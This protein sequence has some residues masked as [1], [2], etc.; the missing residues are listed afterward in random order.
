MRLQVSEINIP[1]NLTTFS[2]IS[3]IFK[4]SKFLF[5]FFFFFSTWNCQEFFLEYWKFLKERIFFNK[6]QNFYNSSGK[7]SWLKFNNCKILPDLRISEFHLQSQTLEIKKEQPRP[8]KISVPI[9][10]R[11][12]ILQRNRVTL[13]SVNSSH[14]GIKL[15]G[16]MDIRFPAGPP[17]TTRNFAAV[18]FYGL[19]LRSI[20]AREWCNELSRFDSS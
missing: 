2:S 13:D 14:S 20:N 17:F 7:K 4:V 10:I 11:K 12:R 5:L 6:F 3:T 15:S 1:W 9:C 19:Q 8:N 18:K 16:T